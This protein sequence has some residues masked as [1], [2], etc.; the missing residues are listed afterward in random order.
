MSTF[1]L[2][3]ARLEVMRTSRGDIRLQGCVGHTPTFTSNALLGMLLAG[4]VMRFE[5]L[6]TEETRTP[7]A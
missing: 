7:H 5:I 6:V 4:A 2:H 1:L 3:L